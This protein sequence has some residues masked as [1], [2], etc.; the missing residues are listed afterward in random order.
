VKEGAV[1]KH[2]AV[3]QQ[4]KNSQQKHHDIGDK[5]CLQIEAVRGSGDL[6]PN[7]SAGSIA[8]IRDGGKTRGSELTTFGLPLFDGGGLDF[9]ARSPKPT[10]KLMSAAMLANIESD[11]T[12]YNASHP[13]DEPRPRRLHKI[14]S[15]LPKPPISL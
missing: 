13:H 2:L 1:G 10:I 9:L 5:K 7:R 8:D 3:P 11:S 12:F 14:G 6:S 4:Q 15:A